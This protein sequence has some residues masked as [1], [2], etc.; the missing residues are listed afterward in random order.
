MLLALAITL[1]VPE[2]SYWPLLLLLLPDAVLRW[3]RR[4]RR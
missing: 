1:A 3:V 4:R 2:T